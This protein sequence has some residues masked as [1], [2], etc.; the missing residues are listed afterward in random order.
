MLKL[1]IVTPQRLLLTTEADYVT[2]PGIVGELGILPGHLPVLTE[3]KS[4]SLS[5]IHQGNTVKIAVH[6]GYAE[7]LE[8]KVTLLVKMAENAEEIDVDRAKTAQ[9]KAESNLVTVGKASDADKG[10]MIRTLEYKLL[11]SI[12]RQQT[13]EK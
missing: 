1:E 5:Y 13:A 3:V 12:A 8:D 4:G 11:R 9:Q 2:I 10:N 6:H 7:V